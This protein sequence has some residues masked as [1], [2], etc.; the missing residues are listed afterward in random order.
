MAKK[1]TT[2][3]GTGS[4]WSQQF[5]DWEKDRNQRVEMSKKMD[6]EGD[7]RPL[8]NRVM[9]TNTN[10]KFNAKKGSLD[11][12]STKWRTEAVKDLP[13]KKYGRKYGDRLTK[14]MDEAGVPQQERFQFAR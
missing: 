2:L 6:A 8:A 1:K 12:G 3:V 9:A 14:L 11:G 13:S 5:N 4:D 10:E 7:M